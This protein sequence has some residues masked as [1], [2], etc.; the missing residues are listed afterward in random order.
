M[1]KYRA[2]YTILAVVPLNSDTEEEAWN[3]IEA[4]STKQILECIVDT[5]MVDLEAY[6]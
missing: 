2:L 4:L 1:A 3:E 6:E 5:E